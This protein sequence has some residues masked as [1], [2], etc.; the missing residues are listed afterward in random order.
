MA[1][2]VN[3][4]VFDKTRTLTTGIYLLFSIKTTN[5]VGNIRL[6]EFQ[7]VNSLMDKDQIMSL[8]ASAE[9]GSE[10]PLAQAIVGY[11][12]QQCLPLF[13][14][15]DFQTVG[16]RGIVCKLKGMEVLVGNEKFMN[17]HGVTTSNFEVLSFRDSI[18]TAV[19]LLLLLLLCC[20]DSIR[21]FAPLCKKMV[22]QLCL[23]HSIGN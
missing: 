9:S 7:V 15:E 22:R 19:I 2:K 13:K 18:I 16:G 6:C 8:I 21:T 12:T 11:A 5:K 10:H 1:H 4:V 23:Q 3:C 20:F 14:P 17:E